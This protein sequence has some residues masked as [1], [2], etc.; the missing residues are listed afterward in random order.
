[1]QT[2]SVLS[3][4]EDK[5]YGFIQPQD[6]GNNVYLHVSALQAAGIDKVEPRQ[7]LTYDLLT[8]E[9]RTSAVNIKLL[10]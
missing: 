3:Y 8:T 9:G 1:M 5:G 6:G 10:G 2:G 4:K 7:R